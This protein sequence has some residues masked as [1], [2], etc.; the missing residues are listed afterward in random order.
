[1]TMFR[2]PKPA[3]FSLFKPTV[4]VLRNY[5]FASVSPPVAA[6]LFVIVKPHQP[7]LRPR[8]KV[9]VLRDCSKC[10]VKFRPVNTIKVLQSHIWPACWRPARTGCNRCPSEYQTVWWK[11]KSLSHFTDLNIQCIWWI[12]KKIIIKNQK[13]KDFFSLI[14][15]D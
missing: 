2:T 8:F 9:K 7:R 13:P 6:E 5:C 14:Y 10:W 3:C 4:S 1:M 11:R 15:W 12:K